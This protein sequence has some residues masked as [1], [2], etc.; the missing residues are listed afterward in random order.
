MTKLMPCVALALLMAASAQAQTTIREPVPQTQVP[1]PHPD[2]SAAVA[3][4]SGASFGYASSLGGEASKRLSPDVDLI[5]AGAHVWNLTPADVAVRA[6]TIANAVGATAATTVHANVLDAGVRVYLP[7]LAARYV[8]PYALAGGGVAFMQTATAFAINGSATNANTLG[9]QL[10]PDLSGTT[11][12]PSLLV[13]GGAVVKPSRRV[14]VDLGFRYDRIFARP[15]Q[16][17][18]DQAL[19]AV[20]LQIGA[21]VRF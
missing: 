2:P 17:P 7:Q 13:G 14:F 3:F 18:R 21:G 9:I 5:V 19:N 1:P 6:R 20:R 12:K 10:G 15:S 4:T 11:I 8:Q 16:I